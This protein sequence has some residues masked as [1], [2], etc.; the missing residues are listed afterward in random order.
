MWHPW[1][2]RLTAIAALVALAVVATDGRAD[3]ANPK[4]N[5]TP[6]DIEQ[7]KT[8]M[9]AGVAFMNDPDGARYEE[10]YPQFRKAYE[11]S[12][13]PNALLNLATCAMKLELDG[14]AIV[15]F[16][17][18]LTHPDADPAD[19]PQAESDL[20]TLKAAVAWVT[21]SASQP[22]TK[23][24]DVRTPRSGP[25]INNSYTLEQGPK[26][27]GIHP[28][29]HEFIAQS[30]DGK[31]LR[32]KIEIGNGSTHDHNFDFAAAPDAVPQPGGGGAGGSG[33]SGPGGVQDDTSDGLHPAVWATG[34]VSI[35]CG[36]TWLA[37]LGTSVS[38]KSEYDDEIRGVKSLEEQE[39]A[40]SE[41]QT[42]NIA[43]DVFLG[44]TGAAVATTIVLAFVL[45]APGSESAKRDGSPQLMVAPTFSPYGSG[46]TVAGTF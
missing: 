17:R 38:K 43:A 44:L 4:Q 26:R 42:I 31:E 32:W 13:S 37:L 19:R 10:A 29:S 18:F 20:G 16:E 39:D 41:L 6:A 5:P 36:I 3:E 25:T 11:L 34:A 24:T 14:E 30:P 2:V 9:T 22:N 40:R 21:L 23:V 15:Y 35:A 28:G 7:A 46:A 27:L 45:P 1:L 8:H 12:G 33:G